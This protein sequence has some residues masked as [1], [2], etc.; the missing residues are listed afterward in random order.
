MREH[1]AVEALDITLFAALLAQLYKPDEQGS[2][3]GFAVIVFS[4]AVLIGASLRGW[5]IA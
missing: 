1:I 3:I 4:L 5:R 2:A